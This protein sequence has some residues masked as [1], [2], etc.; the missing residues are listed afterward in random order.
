[1]L[2]AL[3]QQARQSPR[4]RANHNLHEQLSEPVQ[5]LAIAMEPDTFVRPHRHPQTWELLSALRGR[6]V[7]L[8]FD[9]AGIVTSRTVL[10]EECRV[11][12]FAANTW[13]AVLSLDSGGVIFEVKQGA[14]APL[15]EADFAPWCKS[16]DPQ[17]AARLNAWYAQAQVGDRLQ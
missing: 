13:H 11:I 6:F 5:R 4:L 3:G 8:L 9:E 7:V 17:D 12:E 16:N 15:T 10:G 14:Y 2:D 1:M